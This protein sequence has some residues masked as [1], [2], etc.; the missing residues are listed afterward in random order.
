MIIPQSRLSLRPA[1][2]ERLEEPQEDFSEVYSRHSFAVV[3]NPLFADQEEGDDTSYGGG[4]EGYEYDSGTLEK[5]ED[6]VSVCV[7]VYVCVCVCV[8]EG[9][10]VC[11]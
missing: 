2:K 11:E 9:V 6:L 3:E 7:C 8:C 4:A 1:K 10:S 5:K